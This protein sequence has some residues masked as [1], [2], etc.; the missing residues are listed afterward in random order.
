ME[1]AHGPTPG[2]LL[3]DDDSAFRN[4][5][6]LWLE[7]DRTLHVV[8]EC[9]T[10]E[11]LAARIATLHPDVALVDSVMPGQSLVELMPKLRTSSPRTAFVVY[12]GLPPDGLLANAQAI[13]ADYAVSKDVSSGDLRRV[14]LA[15]L[16][17]R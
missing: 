14:L 16:G 2:V 1:S 9:A 15:Y 6:R 7:A 4:L 3:C 13:G 17:A 11:Q 12:S 8:G 10:A 5:T